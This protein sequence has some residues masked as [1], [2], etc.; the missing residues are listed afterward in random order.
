MGRLGAQL[1][2]HLT[3][4]FSSGHDLMTGGIE[5][6]FRLHANSTEPAWDS[7]SLIFHSLCVCVYTHSLS[8]NKSIKILKKKRKR[9]KTAQKNIKSYFPTLL[10]EQFLE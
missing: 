1:V 8:Q 5:T 3:L 4:D 2:E 6:H 10:F 9:T 7:L